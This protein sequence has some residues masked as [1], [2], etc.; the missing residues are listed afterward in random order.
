MKCFVTL[1]ATASVFLPGC[2][3]EK[4]FDYD[5]DGVTVNGII[6]AK[7]NLDVTGAFSSSPEAP[8]MFYQWNRRVAWSNVGEIINWNMTDEPGD[9]WAPRN[10]PCPRRWRVPTNAEM[11]SLGDLNKVSYQW[12]DVRKGGLFT[13][14]ITGTSVFLPASGL[15]QSSVTNV[16]SLG[17]YW[18]SSAMDEGNGYFMSITDEKS[19]P[20][21][22]GGRSY[23]FSIRC[24]ADR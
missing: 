24:V 15:R 17:F 23:G 4:S 5:L 21:Y 16:G 1:L 2:S 22:F 9:V 14:K 12:D 18:S 7:S 19:F 6:W 20:D 8:G 10:N 3:K 13:D 11:V